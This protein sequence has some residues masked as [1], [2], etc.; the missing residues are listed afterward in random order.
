[1][2]NRYTTPAENAMEKAWGLGTRL[3]QPFEPREIFPRAQGV[4]IRM[5]PTTAH[6]RE[7]VTAMPEIC[8]GR[9]GLVPWFAPTED[10]RYATHNARFE[11]LSQKAS[12]KQA[13]RLGH[14]CIVP[15]QSF[16]EPCWE[17]GRNVWWQFVRRDGQPFA[18]AGL[19]STWTDRSSG[20]LIESYTM[21][22]QNADACPLFRRM[23]KPDPALPPDQQDKR[24]VVILEPADVGT[25]LQG[26]VAQAAAL[27]RSTPPD[28]LLAGPSLL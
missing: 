2:C 3:P 24:S 11:E 12:F 15:A 20:E 22:T 9:W 16:M 27:V 8:L 1:M 5:R 4:F 17:S 13:W 6:H 23:H 18:L 14:R 7:A 19:W 28:R 25:W 21:L 26:S 10:I